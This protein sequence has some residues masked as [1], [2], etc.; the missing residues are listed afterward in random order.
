MFSGHLRREVPYHVSDV[1]QFLCSY[2]QDMWPDANLGPVFELAV[3]MAKRAR[4]I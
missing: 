1:R 4:V 2:G 3:H